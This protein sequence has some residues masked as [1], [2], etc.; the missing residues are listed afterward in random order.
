MADDTDWVASLRQSGG[1]I[2]PTPA[3]QPTEDDS[4]W[5]AALRNSSPPGRPVAPPRAGS[6]PGA[7]GY[8]AAMA[9][10]GPKPTPA[11]RPQMSTAQQLAAGTADA[12][13]LVWGGFFAPMLSGAGEAV[14]RVQQS[15]NS[16]LGIGPKKTRQEVSTEAAGVRDSINRKYGQPARDLLTSMGLIPE[17]ES[18]IG[19]KVIGPAMKKVSEFGEELQFRSGG[20]VLKE[21]VEMYVNGLFGALGAKGAQLSTKAHVDRAKAKY[22]TEEMTKANARSAAADLTRDVEVETREPGSTVT[23]VSGGPMT[24]EQRRAAIAD[25]PVIPTTRIQGTITG[26]VDFDPAAPQGP[27]LL[28]PGT[29]DPLADVPYGPGSTPEQIARW[30]AGRERDMRL[31]DQ[32]NTIILPGDALPDSR[33][34]PT[35]RDLADRFNETRALPSG[36]RPDFNTPGFPRTAALGAAGVAGVVAASQLLDPEDQKKALA[37]GLGVAALT[38]GRKPMRD[39]V[40]MPDSAPWQAFRDSMPYTFKSLEAVDGKR[41]DIPRQQLADR[42]RG[43]DISKF[44]RDTL[45]AVLAK[46]PEKFTAK[47]LALAV[48]EATGD[49]EL[50][51]RTTNEFAD[52][53]LTAIDRGDRFSGAFDDAIDPQVLAEARVRP[54]PTAPGTWEIVDVDGEFLR[55]GIRAATAEEA[56]A[57][58]LR[59]Q[60]MVSAAPA[61]HIYQTPISHDVGNHFNDPNYFGHTRVFEEGG[62]RHVVEVQSDLIQK[63]GKEI[64][65]EERARLESAIAALIPQRKVYS[66]LTYY[67][68]RAGEH[69]DFWSGLE[70]LEKDLPKLHPDA[71]L[72]IEKR[73]LDRFYL[74][75]FGDL[76]H[77]TKAWEQHWATRGVTRPSSEGFIEWLKG[78][79]ELFKPFETEPGGSAAASLYDTF[80]AQ[81]EK[82]GALLAEHKAK[83]T[84]TRADAIR[85]IAK[86][87]LKRLVREEI[88]DARQPINPNYVDL[89]D[90]IP[91]LR[92]A[93]DDFAARMGRLRPEEAAGYYEGV[94]K[95]ETELAQTPTHLPPGKAIRFA[96]ADTVAQVEGWPRVDRANATRLAERVRGA[97]ADLARAEEVLAKKRSSG[98]PESEIIVREGAVAQARVTLGTLKAELDRNGGV[99]QDFRDPGHQGIYDRYAGDYTKFLK[100]LG[101]KHIVDDKGHGWWEIDLTDANK[102]LPAG[103]IHGRPG[104]TRLQMGAASPEAMNAIAVIG[105]LAGIGALLS[106]SD[107]KLEGLAK[108]AATGLGLLVAGRSKAIASGARTALDTFTH[109]FG[110]MSG[111]I[112]RMSMPLLRRLTTHELGLLKQTHDRFNTIAPFVE[113][114]RKLPAALRNDVDLAMLDGN[115]QRVIQLLGQAGNPQLIMD[116]RAAMQLRRQLEHELQ[117]NGRLQRKSLGAFPAIVADPDG[118]IKSIENKFGSSVADQIKKL[119]DATVRETGESISALDLSALLGGRAKDFAEFFAPATESFPLFTRLAT[120]EL[121]RIKFFGADV[122]QGKTT[123]VVNISASIANIV[124]KELAAGNITAR[125]AERMGRLLKARFG[126]GERAIPRAMQTYKNIV[127]T[128]LLANP[129]SAV[130]NLA[131]VGAAAAVHGF[132]PTIKALQAVTLRKPSR[133][134]R[135]DLGLV[136]VMADELTSFR[137]RPFKIGNVEI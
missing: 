121:E 86:D 42:L 80:S 115:A 4:D 56:R 17:G 92:K 84:D 34:A 93:A 87:W 96:D 3:S 94:R 6:I 54:D 29:R 39:L 9:A 129:V 59:E 2:H 35:T 135:A 40:A 16:V 15:A 61:T 70:R 10:R 62:V 55:D 136:D 19:E 83:L 103:G 90:V 51:K 110:S 123:G 36:N 1:S 23:G 50:G 66:G 131:D 26:G 25:D 119:N 47:Q 48:K 114:L 118:L 126:P 46:L 97:E 73:L 130:T 33:P 78:Q 100:Q 63:L 79:K 20:K 72:Q 124:G 102:S 109:V 14:S 7:E 95:A 22:I 21:D 38:V 24:I 53:G 11:P 99:S 116:L 111:E 132:M 134:T 104:S 28:P 77:I 58:V 133:W 76:K 89:R 13:D 75:T 30:R 52:Y 69:A 112:R 107:Q 137:R 120:R 44:E 27:A 37:S 68:S 74:G 125:Q 12:F 41:M 65:P 127:Y 128:T 5:V 43:Q 122:V 88:A 82:T 117:A 64:T 49:F 8:D 32:G 113:G 98:A 108:G 81:W 101:G 57:S 18:Y 60:E 45:T 91:R 67:M 85:P 71:L 105:G 106:D 31:M